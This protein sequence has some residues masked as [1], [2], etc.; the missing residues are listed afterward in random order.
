MDFG[1]GSLGKLLDPGAMAHQLVDSFLPKDMQ[2]V[3]GLVGAAVD[4]ECGNIPGALSQGMSALS[5]LKDMPQ[6][7]SQNTS[8][9]G[10]NAARAAG[11]N[12][13][14]TWSYEPSPPPFRTTTVTTTTTTSSSAPTHPPT[15]EG[16][17]A[18]LRTTALQGHEAP[19]PPTVSR[20][21]TVTTTTTT[22]PQGASRATPPSTTGPAWRGM[23]IAAAPPSTTGPTW[24]GTPPAAPAAQRPS[25]ATSSAAS[26]GASDGVKNLLALSNDDLQRAIASGNVPKDLSN[27]D[28]LALQTRMNQISQMNQLMTQM[29][30]AMHDMQMAVARN[31]HA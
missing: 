17:F 14:P 26:G 11:C 31:I 29:M 6:S 23:P 8:S 1:L 22:G 16:L 12:Q 18:K 30:Q 28:M 13:N 24:R 3:G 9:T 4:Y 2:W 20:T 7:S 27:S 15:N 25:G 10:A 19:T 21:T 5:D